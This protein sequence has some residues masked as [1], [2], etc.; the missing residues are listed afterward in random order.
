MLTRRQLGL[1]AGGS[2]LALATSQLPSPAVAQGKAKVVVIGGGPG[3][4]TTAR[5]IAKDAAGAIDVTLVEP[6]KQFVTCF[7]S[8]LVLGG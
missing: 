8:N 6:S 2:A 1:I 5:Y 7:H 3:G 4:A